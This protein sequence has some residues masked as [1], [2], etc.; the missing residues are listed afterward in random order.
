M[1]AAW[2]AAGVG[3]AAALMSFYMGLERGFLVLIFAAEFDK[4]IAIF[5]SHI[6]KLQTPPNRLL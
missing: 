6:P 5:W 4:V 2:Y 3:G 1:V